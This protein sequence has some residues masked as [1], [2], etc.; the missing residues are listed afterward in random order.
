M[1]DGSLDKSNRNDPTKQ[2]DSL[3]NFRYYLNTF[4]KHVL[5]S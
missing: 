2:L 4:H 5:K 3:D 1:M